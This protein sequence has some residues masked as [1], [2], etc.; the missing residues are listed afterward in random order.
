MKCMLEYMC[1][2]FG[3]VLAS[4]GGVS[5]VLS[6]ASLLCSLCEG[7]GCHCAVCSHSDV[8]TAAD[9]ISVSQTS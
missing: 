8:L 3:A 7:G 9:Q 4:M 2:T 1:C 5:A 6:R